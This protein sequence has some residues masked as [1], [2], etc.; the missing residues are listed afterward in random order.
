MFGIVFFSHQIGGFLG[1]WFGGYAYDTFGSYEMVWWIS[2][3]LGV[4]SALVHWPIRERPVAQL[5]PA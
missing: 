4:A 5:A 3:G 2:S 1:A